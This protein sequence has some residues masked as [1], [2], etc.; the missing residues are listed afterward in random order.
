MLEEP[1]WP[2]ELVNCVLSVSK[3]QVPQISHARQG[4]R[5]HMVAAENPVPIIAGQVLTLWSWGLVVVL[6]KTRAQR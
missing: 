4:P 3:R 6:E 5:Q 2:G 1:P